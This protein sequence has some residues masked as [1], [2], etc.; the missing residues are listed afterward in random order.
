MGEAE[1]AAEAHKRRM[2][3][4]I[5]S[6]QERLLLSVELGSTGGATSSV[7]GAPT[8][9]AVELARL[10]PASGGLIFAPPLPASCGSGIG[11]CVSSLAPPQVSG[12]VLQPQ[13]F[14]IA[15]GFAAQSPGPVPLLIGAP[16]AGGSLPAFGPAAVSALPIGGVAGL[17]H[18]GGSCLQGGCLPVGCFAG[19]CTP[20]VGVASGCLQGGCLPSGFS[21]AGAGPGA[22]LG[23]SCGAISSSPLLFGTHCWPVGLPHE[24]GM[25]GLQQLQLAVS[26]PLVASG[27]PSVGN[28]TIEATQQAVMMQ[29]AAQ[30]Q[31]QPQQGAFRHQVPSAL[32]TSPAGALA[33][34]HLQMILA[35]ATDSQQQALMAQAVQTVQGTDSQQQAWEQS[36]AEDP[37]Q[38]AVMAAAR[39]AQQAQYLQQA[40]FY[41]QLRE[42]DA[43]KARA[44][45]GVGAEGFSRSELEDE[46]SRFKGNFRPLRLCKHFTSSGC[47]RGA[48]CT[49]AHTIEELH[50]ASPDVPRADLGTSALAQTG[51]VEESQIPDVRMKKK[52][53]MCNKFQNNECVLGKACPFAHAESELGTIELVI[54]DKVKTRICKFWE[55]GK[56]IFE[57]NCVN[58]HGEKEIG[59]KR[60]AFMTPPMKKRR[61]DES[62]EDFRASVLAKPSGKE[63][64]GKAKAP[65]KDEDQ[66]DVDG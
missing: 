28:S 22:M 11:S 5:G 37:A 27:Q 21:P 62:V 9:H 35:S 3:A 36:A 7:V 32:P 44:A 13:F 56:C 25:Q 47:W 6:L 65:R 49:Y 52:R 57:K 2:Q 43:A 20:L 31:S 40:Q 16:I 64:A 10:P 55:A 61:A 23:G 29:L 51:K 45:K 19:G 30:Q 53:E 18:P 33:A 39:E 60:P 66:G 54:T 63:H 24:A 8:R 17:V 34:Q 59:T 42:E 38:I 41:Q 46:D 14:G 12:A 4:A 1:A 48:D 26:D 50:P 15:Q 58:A